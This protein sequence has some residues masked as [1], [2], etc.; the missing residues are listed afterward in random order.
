[1]S[2]FIH[3]QWPDSNDILCIA[4]P[5]WV[6]YEYGLIETQRRSQKLPR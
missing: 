6:K 4:C 1:M 2:N 3:H 5:E